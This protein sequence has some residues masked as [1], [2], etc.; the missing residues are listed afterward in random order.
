MYII[1]ELK[2]NLKKYSGRTLIPFKSF[3]GQELERISKLEIEQNEK[4][5]KSFRTKILN[6]KYAINVSPLYQD[7]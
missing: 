2:Q 7:Y 5:F 1:N 3:E 6:D 4:D